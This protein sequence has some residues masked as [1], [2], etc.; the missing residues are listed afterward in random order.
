MSNKLC[1]KAWRSVWAVAVGL[2]SAVGVN[3]A[4][5]V[6]IPPEKMA[7]QP[8]VTWLS[9]VR[10]LAP[11]NPTVKPKAPRRILVFNLYTGYHHLVIPYAD[12]MLKI[13]AAKSG[14]FQLD[15][16]RDIEVFTPERLQPYDA[17]LLNNCCSVG[18]HRNIFR[19]VLFSDFSEPEL[20]ALGAPYQAMTDEQ[21]KARA[22]ALEGSLISY[23][24][25]GHGL[26]AVHGAVVMQNSSSE[27]G[28]MIGANFDYHPRSQ[29]VNVYPVDSFH[30][31]LRTFQ[32][33]PFVHVDEPYIFNGAYATKNFRPLLKLMA[34][35]VK[36]K[37]A[38]QKVD[39]VLYISWIKRHGRGRVFYVSPSHY[40]ESYLSE[41]M[42][43]FYLDGIQYAVGDLKCDDKPLRGR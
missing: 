22:A 40:P 43:R 38:G 34:S 15:F 8:S 12:E 35:E 20:K 27:Y 18:Q 5:R 26:I 32:G 3:A 9:D 10:E 31:L 23:V 4:E 24:L 41:R 7:P 17:V 2:V 19:D 29:L 39:D 25:A 42:L 6:P 37:K 36:D 1:N 16:S 21:R 30:P 28:E 33:E 11:L 14:A 13:L